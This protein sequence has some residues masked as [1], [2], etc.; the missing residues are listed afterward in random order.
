MDDLYISGTKPQVDFILNEIEKHFTIG[1]VHTNVFRYTGL[2][3]ELKREGIYVD[4]L[5]YIRDLETS[6]IRS[7]DRTD[8]CTP[9]ETTLLRHN[10]GGVLWVAG[11]TRPDCAWTACEI[12]TQFKSA[13]LGALKD[14][15]K[16]ITKLRASEVKILYPKFSSLPSFLIWADASLGNLPNK[17]DT[18]GG[19]IVLLVDKEGNSAP[20]GWVANKIR[21]KVGSTLSAEC[22]ILLQATDHAFYL[23]GLLSE[24]VNVEASKFRMIAMTDSKNLVANL[25]SVHQPKEYRLRFEIAQ[26]QQYI[27]EGLIVKHVPGC[28]Q[29]A[30][31][32][33]KRTASSALLLE[34]LTK[35]QLPEQCKFSLEG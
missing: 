17:V 8:K 18:G 26:L 23:R 30:D 24:I 32:L 12:S 14:S 34:C 7:G 16:L 6:P 2:Q 10:V 21:R 33:S 27:S 25:N 3:L 31:P 11:A 9:D 35:G 15:N 1:K 19:Y 13:T 28:S 20:I 29:L 4:Q 5:S 22:L